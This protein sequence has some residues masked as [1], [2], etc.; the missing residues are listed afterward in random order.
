MKAKKTKPKRGRKP[1]Q[2][3]FMALTV[4]RQRKWQLRHAKAGLCLKCSAPAESGG[5]C[6]EHCIQVRLA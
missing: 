2:D 1:I 6:R 4:S 3:E 5:L